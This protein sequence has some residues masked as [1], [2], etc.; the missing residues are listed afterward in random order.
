MINYSKNNRLTPYSVAENSSKYIYS[1]FFSDLYSFLCYNKKDFIEDY[2]SS[3]FAHKKR[4]LEN[5]DFGKN[6]DFYILHLP[7]K[8]LDKSYFLIISFQIM[9]KKI[10]EDIFDY[11]DYPCSVFPFKIRDFLEKEKF[12]DLF[13]NSDENS[14]F[15]FS[16][17]NQNYW[18]IIKEAVNSFISYKTYFNSGVTEEDFYWRNTPLTFTVFST[19]QLSNIKTPKHIM[20]KNPL[21]NLEQGGIYEQN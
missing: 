3:G 2:I 12:E 21:K 5:F 14:G 15:S 7:C 18:K 8:S 17:M 4:H 20:D 13:V 9:S 10:N 16:I 6:N 1:M 11:L 19:A